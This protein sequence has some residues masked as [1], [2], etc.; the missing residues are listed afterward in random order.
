MRPRPLLLAAF[1]SLLPLAPLAA[2]AAQGDTLD[3]LS[4]KAKEAISQNS[5]ESAVKILSRAKQL[6]PTSPRAS[7][8]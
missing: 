5:Y 2:Q 3:T 8:A 4:S 1:I 6:Y 7:L